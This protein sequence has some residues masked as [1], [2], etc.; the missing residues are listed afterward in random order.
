[1]NY[2]DAYDISFKFENKAIEMMPSTYSFAIEDSIYE[3]YP[4]GEFILKDE[5]G[6][7]QEYLMTVEGAKYELSIGYDEEYI[8][9][10]LIVQDD[11][12]SEATTQGLINGKVKVNLIHEFKGEQTL[13]SV[14]YKN[15]ISNIVSSLKGT[16]S[17]KS[18]NIDSTG[19]NYE[20]YRLLKGQVDF[21][22]ENLLPFAYS[23]SFNKSPYFFF[24]DSK[25]NYNFK[26]YKSMINSSNPTELT[27]STG[28]LKGS[29]KTSILG[30]KRLRKGM[31][32]TYDLRHRIIYSFDS[33]TG[34]PIES[35]DYIYDYPN[36]VSSIPI[37][38]DSDKITS[39]FLQDDS[40]SSNT[41][42]EKE[43]LKGLL[44]SSMRKG[45]TLERFVLTL[46]F[47]PSLVAGKPVK[48][49]I[50][51]SEGSDTSDFNLTG[52][53]LIEKSVVVWDG[54]NESAIT[55]CVVGRKDTYLPN[56]IYKMKERL[57]NS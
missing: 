25:N 35:E 33:N 20:W 45:I 19:N 9:V 8:S 57:I 52:V 30:I 56:S 28:V 11:S 51:T 6:A 18:T 17:F 38:G 27:L 26:C 44:N 41:T 21:I 46:P 42:A 24:I 23:Q 16:Y 15:S 13:Q 14:Y 2:Q 34:E 12:L 22:N 4:K 53:Y 3:A 48:I 1:M 36:N 37:V 49:I 47:N 31:N 43:N 32:I 29:T 54:D 55:Y 40:N 5:T 7:L 39:Y 50:P 10:P